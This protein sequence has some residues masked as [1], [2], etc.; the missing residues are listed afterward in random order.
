MERHWELPQFYGKWPFIRV[1]GMQEPASVLFSLLN[2]WAHLRGLKKLKSTVQFSA[3]Y[4]YMWKIFSLICL[5]A[6]TWSMI[7]HTRDTFLTEL[8][9]YGCAYSMVL[10]SFYCMVSRVVLH[11]K[12]VWLKYFMV[13][14]LVSYFICHFN[15]LLNA[16]AYGYNMKVNVTTGTLA[17]VGWLVWCINQKQKRP[18]VWKMATF[19]IFSALSLVLELQD[20]PPIYWILDA[21]ALWHLVTAPLVLPL[22][23]FIIDDTTSLLNES[24]DN[25][26]KLP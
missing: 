10:S 20:F 9:D 21:H 13:A 12:P 4:F 8:M 24:L 3:P 15:F 26:K 2:F 6:W 25:Q 19:V 11:H 5:N 22:Y 18:Y 16:R 1:F 14:F 17:G 23:S 7:F